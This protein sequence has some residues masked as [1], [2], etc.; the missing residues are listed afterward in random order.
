M[1]IFNVSGDY[2]ILYT[3]KGVFYVQGG[4]RFDPNTFANLDVIVQQEEAP[5]E[6]VIPDDVSPNSE[7]V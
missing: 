2:S 1:A 3:E 6:N 5:V 4:R 7:F